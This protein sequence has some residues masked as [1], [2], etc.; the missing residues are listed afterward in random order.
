MRI[1]QTIVVEGKSDEAK[2]KG[3]FPA[4][5]ITTNGTHLGKAKLDLIRQAQAQNGVIIF[6]DP[7]HPGDMIRQKINEAVPG[8]LNAFITS[9][10]ARHKQK[11]GIEHAEVSE[12]IQALNQL[13]TYQE[14]PTGIGY[15]QLRGLGLIGSPESNKLRMRLCR[16]LNIGLCNGKTLIKRLNMAGISISTLCEVT[17]GVINE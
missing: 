11:V 10:K 9:D 3:I 5:V 1:K 15:A 13:I 7:D 14:Q 17:A 8:C 16:K 12:I 2:L 6:T 4:E